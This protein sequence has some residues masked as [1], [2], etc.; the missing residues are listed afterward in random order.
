MDT[1]W[2][3]DSQQIDSHKFYVKTGDWNGTQSECGLEGWT[4][5]W[6]RVGVVDQRRFVEHA[7][8]VYYAV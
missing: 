5:G 2:F 6:K 1:S 4:E 3:M 7:L 8:F